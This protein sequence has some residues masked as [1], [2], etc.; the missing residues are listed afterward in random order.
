[1]ETREKEFKVGDIVTLDRYNHIKD[2]QKVKIIGFSETIKT[3][4][5]TYKL[6]VNGVTIESTGVSIVE[7]KDYNPVD[8]KLRHRR[9]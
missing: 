4:R 6:D 2:V 8:N 7:S 5:L 9:V 3:K 1:M